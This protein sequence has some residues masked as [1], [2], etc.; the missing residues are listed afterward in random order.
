M[1]E[2]LHLMVECKPDVLAAYPA[3]DKFVANF[4]ARPQVPQIGARAR[5][6]GLARSA[7]AA[8]WH[9]P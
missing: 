7:W 8:A 3:L 2:A 4:A 6:C 9:G 1:F 5:L